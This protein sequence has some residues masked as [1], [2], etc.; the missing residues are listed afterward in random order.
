M[1]N[2]LT[3]KVAKK[4]AKVFGFLFKYGCKFSIMLYCV[5]A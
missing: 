5:S 3:K 4:T 2:N 1:K